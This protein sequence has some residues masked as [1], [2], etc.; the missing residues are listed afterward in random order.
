M[1]N[2]FPPPTF[3]QLQLSQAVVPISKGKSSISKDSEDF[4]NH[5]DSDSNNEESSSPSPDLYTIKIGPP[6][7]PPVGRPRSIRTEPVLPQREGDADFPMASPDQERVTTQLEKA[8]AK[9]KGW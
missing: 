7:G 2:L 6:V 8:K 9:T 4:S 5:S 1:L 3:L